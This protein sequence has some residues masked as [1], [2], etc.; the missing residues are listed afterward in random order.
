MP[1]FK[2]KLKR[3]PKVGKIYKGDQVLILPPGTIVYGHEGTSESRIHRPDMLIRLDD[4]EHPLK[5]IKENILWGNKL[6]GYY[7]HTLAEE[8][9]EQ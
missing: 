4:P 8:E 5:N 2:I 6:G 3:P 1:K 7:F 9:E